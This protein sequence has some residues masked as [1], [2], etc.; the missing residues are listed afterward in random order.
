[1]AKFSERIKRYEKIRPYLRDF[2]IYGIKGRSDYSPTKRRSYDNERRRIEDYLPEY[3]K[4][5]LH[6]LG[7]SLY[8][9]PNLFHTGPNPLFNTYQSKS[10]TKN[11][12][13][14]HFILLD[15]LPESDPAF[16][17]P[18]ILKAIESYVHQTEGYT[19]PDT[20]TVRNKL[21]EYSRI[22]LIEKKTELKKVYYKRSPITAPIFT[23]LDFLQD[24]LD[25]YQHTS[26]IGILGYF[27]MAANREKP[28][29]SSL[30]LDRQSVFCYKHVYDFHIL[31]YNILTLIFQAMREEKYIDIITYKPRTP[32][33]ALV[34]PVKIL[35]NLETGRQYL[36]AYHINEKR[37]MQ[38]RLDKIKGIKLYNKNEDRRIHLRR[39]NKLMDTTFGVSLS[40]RQS[41]KKIELILKIDERHEKTVIERIQREGY[42]GE[43]EWISI[44]HFKYCI[45]VKDPNEMLPWLRTFIGR[46]V[47]FHCTDDNVVR[48]FY[49]DL[50]YMKKMYHLD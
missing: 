45:H 50:Y 46:I 10:F 9:H 22:G 42:Q 12:L 34:L 49:N 33:L 31:D 23:K 24:A 13:F 44:N 7:K 6:S 40:D 8:I 37:L 18:E 47:S 21:N 30:T 4:E 20:M 17:M 29:P 25:F 26:P 14:L 11:D 27:L 1:M 32:L 36:V 48:K 19:M 15:L 28:L 43:L 5:Q 39:L 41:T 35:N 16:G 2:L 3:T 38:F